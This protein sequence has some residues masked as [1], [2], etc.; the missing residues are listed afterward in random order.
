[1]V[2]IKICGLR[3]EE[4]ISYVNECNP[5]YVGFVFAK[6]RRQVTK[7]QAEKLRS[8]LNP[9]IVPVGVFVNEDMETIAKLVMEGIID[10]AQLHGDETE[11]DIEKLRRLTNKKV[12]IIKAIRVADKADVEK[13]R[14]FSADYLLF[15]SFSQKEYGGTGK[16]FDWMLLNEV[17]VPYFLAGGISSIN[18]EEAAESLKPYAF[19]VSSAVETDGCKDRE[20]ILSL[21]DKVR[22]INARR[23]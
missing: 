2:K 1:M 6:S 13:S 19:D 21:M 5:D 18:M 14:D 8:R 17:S 20:K 11:H 3:R 7:E 23:W 9:G 15:D 4:D 12:Q 10:I 16:T 22:Q